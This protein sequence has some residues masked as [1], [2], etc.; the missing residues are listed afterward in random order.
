MTAIMSVSTIK[1]IHDRAYQVLVD[2]L[3]KARQDAQLTQTELAER[4]RTDQSYVSRYESAER[5][6]DVIELRA[7][8]REFGRG[9]AEF[10]TDFERELKR[11]GLS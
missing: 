9:L 11:K 8:C 4:L 10:I 1:T 6:L 7:I 2:C 3:R 5:R